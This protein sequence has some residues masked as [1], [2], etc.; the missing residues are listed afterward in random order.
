MKLYVGNISKDVTEEDLKQEF[1]AFGTVDSV[2]VIKDKFSRMSK[3]FAF[4]EMGVQAE[5]EAAIAGLHRKDL[6]G[7]SMDVNE[8]RPQTERKGG[9]GGFRGG[10]RKGGGSG[11]GGGFRGGNGGGKRW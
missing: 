2:A 7:Q 5:A 1:A 3:G 6:K 11:G 10:A 9:S 8:A 4:V